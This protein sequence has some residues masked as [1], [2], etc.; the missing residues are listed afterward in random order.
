[1]EYKGLLL[2]EICVAFNQMPTYK[3]KFKGTTQ[4]V[5]IY[6]HRMKYCYVIMH[7]IDNVRIIYVENGRTEL[8]V[9]NKE[10]I[11]KKIV[12]TLYSSKL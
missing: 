4:V 8:M 1:M 5:A 7:D 11:I 9:S 2:Y 12:S 3:A 10:Y 6:Y